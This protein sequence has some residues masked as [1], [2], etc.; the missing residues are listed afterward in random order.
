MGDRVGIRVGGDQII[1]D[2]K[3]GDPKSDTLLVAGGIGINP[4][5]SILQHVAYLHNNGSC[6]LGRV[7]ML[8]SASCVKELIFKVRGEHF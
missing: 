7:K 1:Y 5:I 2:P 3:P 4:L 6:D 8:Y